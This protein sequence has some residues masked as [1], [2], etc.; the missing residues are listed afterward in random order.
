MFYGAYSVNQDVSGW[1]TSNVETMRS[2]FSGAS[3]F[4]QD[5][6]GWCVEQITQKPR[7]FDEDA[8]FEGDNTK[9][10]NWGDAC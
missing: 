9:Q 2:M 3:S 4:D 10:P 1:N 6:S 7:R 5:I 8:G